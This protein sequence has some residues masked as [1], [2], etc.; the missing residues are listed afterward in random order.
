MF[1]ENYNLLVYWQE[2]VHRLSSSY[3][4]SALLSYCTISCSVCMLDP[5]II[6]L[7]IMSI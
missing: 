1:D 2:L 6:L 5:S 4:Y 7:T 3:Y